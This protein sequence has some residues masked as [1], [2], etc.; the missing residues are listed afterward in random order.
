[1]NEACSEQ[2]IFQNHSVSYSVNRRLLISIQ[3]ETQ[4]NPMAIK[5]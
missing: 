3:N 1:V 4:D 5:Y 2:E